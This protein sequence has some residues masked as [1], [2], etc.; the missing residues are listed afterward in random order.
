MI[1]YVLIFIFSLISVVFF[2]KNRK[3]TETLKVSNNLNEKLLKAYEKSI[4]EREAK[5]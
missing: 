4:N 2:F 3:L 1:S 5:S